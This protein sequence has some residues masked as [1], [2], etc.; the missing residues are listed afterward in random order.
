[1]KNLVRREVIQTAHTLVVKIGTNVLSQE[2]GSLDLERLQ[3]LAEQFH[4]VRASNRQVV[5]VSSGAVGAGIGLLNLKEKPTD[6]PH[7]QAAAS[8]GQAHLIRL[9]DDALKL[10]GSHAAQLLLTANDFRNRD[11]YLNVRNTINTLLE[12]DVVPIINENDTVSVEEIKFG[13]N[14]HLAAMVTHLLQAPLLVILSSVDGLY[15]GDPQLPESK[16]IPLVSEWNDDLMR[17]VAPVQTLFGSG[18]MGSKLKA[19]RTATQVGESVILANGTTNG[20]LDHILNGEEVGTLF[21]AEGSSVPAWKR[22]IGY[23]MTPHGKLIIDQGACLAILEKGRSLLPI[24]IK[25][26]EGSFQRG[27]VISIQNEKNEELARGLI[28]YNSQEAKII[29][30]KPSSDI[31]A[32]LG[33]LPYMEMVHRNNLVLKTN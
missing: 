27:E 2:N 24:G 22:W 8:V 17:H 1:M 28:N 14:D 20:I 18:G 5:V 32:L 4:K 33:S 3:H 15:D 10:H 26:I 29:A 16:R 9:Y 21:L 31:P 25:Q 30:G 23:T 7:L 11:R 19:V 6:L 13:D 12:F